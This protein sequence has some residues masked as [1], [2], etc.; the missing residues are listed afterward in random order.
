M[1]KAR[2]NKVKEADAAQKGKRRWRVSRRGFLIGTGVVGAGLALGWRYGLPEARLAIANNL[3]TSG[4]P[5]QTE[6]PVT[7]WFEVLPD[8]QMVL[9][10]PK[11][12]MGQGVHT[13]LGQIAAEELEFPFEQ[14]Q[15]VSASTNRGIKDGFG[16]GASN[17][18]STLFTP[19]REAAAT[20]R[21]MLRAKAAEKWNVEVSNVVAMDGTFFQQTNPDEVMTYGEVVESVSE[22]DIP[23]DVPEL[24][25]VSE[26]RYIGKALKRVDFEDKLTGRAIYG[27]DVRVPGMLYGAVA[28]PPTIGATLESASEGSARE[29]AGVVDVVLQ[30]GF[31]GVVAKTRAQAYRGVEALELNW[32]AAD[33]IQQADIDALVQVSDSGGVTIQREGRTKANLSKGKLVEGEYRSPMAAHAHLEPQAAMVDVKPDKVTAQVSTQSPRPRAR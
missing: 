33:P 26:F 28:R 16:T 10:M 6:G 7:A 29:Q 11:V 32:K 24:K 2:E 25:P 21:E 27:Y 31:A 5:G 4:A 22:W 17:T 30:E 1:A 19:L 18:I 9:Y 14:L 13:S 3:E 23:K 8:N 12:E 20:M 15:V